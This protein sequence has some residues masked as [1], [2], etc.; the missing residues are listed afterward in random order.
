MVEHARGSEWSC[1]QDRR[2][3]RR[4]ARAGALKVLRRT[5]R[6]ILRDVLIHR[7]RSSDAGYAVSQKASAGSVARH[8]QCLAGTGARPRAAPDPPVER[9]ASS[10]RERAL[11]LDE[12]PQVP[13]LQ[14]D[15]ADRLA[16]MQA[17]L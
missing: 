8:P 5:R 9:P 6:T 15:R 3:G 16:L 17:D 2:D 13:R 1:S 10:C 7:A 11:A 4:R 14:L 12:L